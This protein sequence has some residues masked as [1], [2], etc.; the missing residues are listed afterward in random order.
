MPQSGRNREN[1]MLDAGFDNQEEFREYAEKSGIRFYL[2]LISIEV[3]E[4]H[5]LELKEKIVLLV[6]T[7]ILAVNFQ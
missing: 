7:V 6:V 3:L 1:I 2:K 5:G 4:M